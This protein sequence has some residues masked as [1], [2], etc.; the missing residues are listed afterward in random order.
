MYQEQKENIFQQVLTDSFS[1]CT[2]PPMNQELDSN[3]VSGVASKG[4]IAR[5][6][7]LSSEERSEIARNAVEARWRKAGKIMEIPVAEWGSPDHPLRIPGIIEDIPCYVLNDKRRV[8]VQ[9]GMMGALDMKQGTAGR[10]TGDRL[11]RFLATRSIN[12][13]VPPHLRDMIISPIKFKAGG[14]IAYGYE[15]TI[16]ADMCDAVLDARQ[17]GK[18]NYQQDHIAKRCEI[19]VRGFARVGIIALVDEATGFQYDR[20]RRDLEEQLRKFLAEDLT[21][22][23]ESFP[24]AY[25]RHLCRLRG[26]ELRPDMRL[27]SYFGHLTNDLVYRRIAPGLLKALKDRRAEKGKKSNKLYWWTSKDVGYPAMV[28][29][30]GRV[31]TLMELNTDYDEFHKELDRLVPK[32]AAEPGLFDSDEEW[33]DPGLPS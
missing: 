24:P 26:V 18:L 28:F 1:A 33:N 13:F 17:K 16:L 14:S 32:Y 19:L 7:S 27:P 11:V 9:S 20:P 4:G 3:S 6:K 21:R 8:I 12:P 5:A 2:I 10:G 30:L 29:H 23:V 22:Y 15:A 25:F 31:T